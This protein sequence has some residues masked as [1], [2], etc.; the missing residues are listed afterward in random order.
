MARILLFQHVPFE[1]LGVISPLIR[2]RGHRIRY[3]NFSREPEAKPNL[4]KYEALIIL[5]GPANVDQLERYPYLQTE[6]DCIKQALDNDIPILGICLGGQLLA[7][8]CGAEVY[9]GGAKEIG[10]TTL[11]PTSVGNNDP[12]IQHWQPEEKIFQ[13]HARTFDLP[14]EANLLVTGDVIPNQAFV[15]GNHA[16]GFQFHLE[17]NT[18]LISRWVYLPMYQSDLN[19]EN[20]RQHAKDILLETKQYLPR[21]DEL[22]RQV[23]GAFLD[24]LPGVDR[25]VSLPTR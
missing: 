11:K 7:A 4:S 21:S 12:L 24:L 15:I 13:W 6:M 1:P 18:P 5:G 14:K 20:P 9:K 3:I 16:Y 8:A 25:K 2:N 22:A 19:P 10:W 23:F 17:V